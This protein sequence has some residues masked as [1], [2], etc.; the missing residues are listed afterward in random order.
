MSGEARPAAT[1]IVLAGGRA[2]RFGSDKLAVPLEGRPLLQRAVAAVAEVADEVVV[3]VAAG[4]AAPAPPLEPADRVRVVRDAV[5]GAGPL[6]GLA[7]GLAAATRPLA[8]LVG[9]DQPWLR[10]DLLRALL[11]ELAGERGA[12]VDVAA[13]ADGDHLWP[14]PVALRVAAALPAA[15]AG[16]AGTDHR[17]FS[18]LGRLRVVRLSEE[19]WRALDPQ[20]ASLLDVDRPEDLGRL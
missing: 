17:L 14:F 18:L 1:G 16:L 12:D 19:R 2:T 3:V 7:A 15:E 9:G 4:G 20:G 8:L 6:A 10:P 11:E 13:L 5:A